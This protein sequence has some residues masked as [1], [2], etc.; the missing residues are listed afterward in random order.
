MSAIYRCGFHSFHIAN[1]ALHNNR[2]RGFLRKFNRHSRGYILT[3]EWK[4]INQ[5]SLGGKNFQ[6]IIIRLL[7]KNLQI[8]KKLSQN[9]DLYQQVVEHNLK[10]KL[11]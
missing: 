1:L 7:L 9:L 10:S 5:K 8:Y 2:F 3:I 4:R 6:R 11:R